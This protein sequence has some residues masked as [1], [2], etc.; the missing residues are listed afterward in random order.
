ML[1]RILTHDTEPMGDLDLDVALARRGRIALHPQWQRVM[2]PALF[3]A[4]SEMRASLSC[5]S[6]RAR[7]LRSC[8]LR[9]RR[10]STRRAISSSSSVSPATASSSSPFPGR[11]TA[12]CLMIEGKLGILATPTAVRLGPPGRG[13]PGGESWREAFIVQ[14]RVARLPEG[15]F[16]ALLERIHGLSTGPSRGRLFDGV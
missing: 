15:Y 5:R 4:I 6:S 3:G 14:Q 16:G 11:S 12:S 10:S 1:T 9:S 13:S 2:L 8:S 7:M